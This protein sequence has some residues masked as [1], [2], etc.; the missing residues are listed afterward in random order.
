M[1]PYYAPPP[2][3]PYPLVVLFQGQNEYP[4]TR[5]T[6][7]LILH[8][9][10]RSATQA[11]VKQPPP[12]PQFNPH[13]PPIRSCI[14]LGSWHLQLLRLRLRGVLSVSS[15]L[16]GSRLVADV[17]SRQSLLNGPLVRGGRGIRIV[18]RFGRPVLD[19]LRMVLV[20]AN[21]LKTRFGRRGDEVVL[22]LLNWFDR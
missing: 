21:L 13:F 22:S 18:S 11:R 7:D 20:E 8:N 5:Q 9:R 1:G 6:K 14:A 15:C 2:P 3:P 19:V 17:L 4:T 12:H 16:E 10:T